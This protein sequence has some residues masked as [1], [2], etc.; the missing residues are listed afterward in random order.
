MPMRDDQI[1]YVGDVNT[2]LAKFRNVS[3][4]ELANKTALEATSPTPNKLA[5]EMVDGKL[6][7][8]LPSGSYTLM[9]QDGTVSSNLPDIFSKTEA[10]YSTILSTHSY[11]YCNLNEFLVDSSEDSK[12]ASTNATYDVINK[13]YTFTNGQTIETSNLITSAQTEFMIYFENTGSFIIEYSLVPGTWL[14]GLTNSPIVVPSTN[15]FR[16]KL[17]ASG[18]AELSSI[19]LFF[20]YL[21]NPQLSQQS[22]GS[23]GSVGLVDASDVSV[24]SFNSKLAGATT[25]QESL[26]IVDE[27]DFA[28]SSHS[29]AGTSVSISPIS[30]NTDFTGQLAGK[31]VDNVQKLAEAVDTLS[32]SNLNIERLT[33]QNIGANYN[34]PAVN[35]HYIV[36]LSPATVY[37]DSTTKKFTL[38]N[39]VSLNHN[40]KIILE[41]ES[42]STGASGG[43]ATAKKFEFAKGDSSSKFKVRFNPYQWSSVTDKTEIVNYGT[44]INSVFIYYAFSKL[45]SVGSTPFA[46]EKQYNNRFEITLDKLTDPTHPIWFIRSIDTHS[47]MRPYVSGS[48]YAYLGYV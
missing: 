26:D 27:F 47:F 1:K 22:G 40:D 29:H 13:K 37:D 43:A 45:F 42:F 7:A 34:L 36:T 17:T 30:P 46:W 3:I 21:K 18:S 38:P 20:G 4:Y 23:G 19:G 8:V 28:Q 32:T 15:D 14:I 44:S 41:I 11:R 5:I 35:K 10:E 48:S 24:N 9:N 12:I 33:I 2:E 31:G 39:S 25:V 6:N 16:I